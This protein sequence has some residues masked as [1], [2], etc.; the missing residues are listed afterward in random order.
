LFA[1][2]SDQYTGVPRMR[3]GNDQPDITIT[4][5]EENDYMEI[6][7]LPCIWECAYPRVH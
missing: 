3:I 4:G 7:A 2:I 1:V 5:N 6:S